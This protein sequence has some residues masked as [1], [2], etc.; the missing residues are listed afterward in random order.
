MKK[1]VLSKDEREPKEALLACA[2]IQFARYFLELSR[3]PRMR[4]CSRQ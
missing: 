3:E 1:P 2:L 4:G